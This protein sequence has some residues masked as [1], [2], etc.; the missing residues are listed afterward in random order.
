MRL[1][2]T[3]SLCSQCFI[4]KELSKLLLEVSEWLESNSPVFYTAGATIYYRKYSFLYL[5]MI[6]SLEE[7]SGD[8]IITVYYVDPKKYTK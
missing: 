5:D 3:S 2:K 8:H 7:E 6:V 1:F 4:G